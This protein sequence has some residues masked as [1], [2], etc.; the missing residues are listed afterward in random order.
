MLR[1][2]FFIFLVLTAFLA[3]LGFASVFSQWAS[4]A[5]ADA[6]ALALQTARAV[7]AQL[8]VSPY[9]SLANSPALKQALASTNKASTLAE[10]SKRLPAALLEEAFP[11]DAEDI[12]LLSEKA[13]GKALWLIDN[14]WSEKPPEDYSK[15]V[16][17]DAARRQ[18]MVEMG[19]GWKVFFSIKL[20]AEADS[21]FHLWIGGPAM[22]FWEPK[23]EQ[24]LKHSSTSGLGVVVSG[25]LALQTGHSLSSLNTAISSIKPGNVGMLKPLNKQGGG[26]TFLSTFWGTLRQL[27]SDE[28]AARHPI[29]TG[30]AELVLILSKQATQEALLSAQQTVFYGW[31]TLLLL[32][33]V[34]GFVFVPSRPKPAPSEEVS[35][36]TEQSFALPSSPP[37]ATQ[38]SRK[39]AALEEE[40]LLAELPLPVTLPL[41]LSAP[42]LAPPELPELPELPKPLYTEEPFNVSPELPTFLQAQQPQMPPELPKPLPAEESLETLPELSK[43][44][45]T[46]QTE[47]PPQKLS[48]APP[49]EFSPAAEMAGEPFSLGLSGKAVQPEEVLG[50]DYAP[51]E[52]PAALF[53]ATLREE[54]ERFLG[55]DFLPEH[56]PLSGEALA[57]SAKEPEEAEWRNVFAEFLRVRKQCN[58]DTEGLSFE[59]FKTKLEASKNNLLSKHQCKAVRFLVQIKD[60]KAALKAIPVRD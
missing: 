4:R 54:A 16:V 15:Q 59:R 53:E 49:V 3:W 17:E 39:A 55:A 56:S 37:L 41:P 11:W 24:E 42:P 6:E 36:T 57:A 32:S 21:G 14:R 10:V 5:Q 44:L 45:Q 47:R 38:P 20:P 29:N 18:E 52:N 27:S 34:A 33:V 7:A 46:L 50:E 8:P 51:H 30:K 9:A 31:L 40:E 19:N 48:P 28:I 13:S 60:G 1:L 25:K 12:A 26:G 23:L 22:R 43:L 35:E 2:K 58:Q